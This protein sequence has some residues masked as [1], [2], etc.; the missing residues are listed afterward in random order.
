[1]SPKVAVYYSE[2]TGTKQKW[3]AE[4]SC[5]DQENTA[6]MR[7]FWDVTLAGDDS[8]NIQTHKEILVAITHVK[9]GFKESTIIHTLLSTREGGGTK[10]DDQT[11]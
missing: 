4:S 11:G 9:E 5:E 6:L 8:G 10:Q 1:M 3:E 7:K 2:E